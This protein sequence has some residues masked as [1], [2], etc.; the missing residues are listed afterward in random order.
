MDE[1]RKSVIG[2]IVAILTSLHMQNAEDL[3]GGTQGSHG[4][5]S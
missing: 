4:P 2:I 1:G 3:F 5:T